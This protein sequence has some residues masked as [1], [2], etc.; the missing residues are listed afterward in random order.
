MWVWVG[1]WVSTWACTAVSD[2]QQLP[3]GLQIT[4]Y[5]LIYG[6]SGSSL[7]SAGFSLVAVSGG[8]SLVV[9]SRFLMVVAFLVV[10]HGLQGALA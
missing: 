2:I 10:E 5:F 1:G 9:V 8:P 3:L 7:L 6:C 4:F